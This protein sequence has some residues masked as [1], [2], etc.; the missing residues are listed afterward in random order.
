MHR[1]GENSDST[2]GFDSHRPGWGKSVH[3]LM[4]EN[5]ASIFFH[6]HD[7]CYAKQDKDGVVYQEVPQPSSKNITLFTGSQYGYVN[8]VL[9]PSR[10]F[11][12]VTVTDSTA[13]VDYIKTYLPAEETGGHVNGEVATS[14]TIRSTVTSVEDTPGTAT[15]F[16]L[17]QNYPNPFISRTTIRYRVAM[18]GKVRITVSDLLGRETG[19]LVDQIQQPGSYMVSFNPEQN[20][21]MGGILICRMVAGQYS[22]TI[23]MVCIQ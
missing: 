1:C 8:G 20:V 17:D 21:S 9:M 15:V 22:K 2:W 13:R 16:H 6:G 19:T 10:G 23:K 18:A 5:H 3:T 4:M 12:L 11:L 14:Y 7:H